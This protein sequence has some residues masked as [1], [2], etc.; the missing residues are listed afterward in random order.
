MSNNT[1]FIAPLSHV[2]PACSFFLTSQYTHGDSFFWWRRVG[3]IMSPARTK[4]TGREEHCHVSFLPFPP[5]LFA[6][7]PVMLPCSV[8]GA[9]LPLS[10]SQVHGKL[11]CGVWR[12]ACRLS[13]VA[14]R[15]SLAA[16]LSRD[17]VS[18]LVVRHAIKPA[19]RRDAAGGRVGE[20]KG[21]DSAGKTGHAHHTRTST[22]VLVLV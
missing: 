18:T 4:S 17:R 1:I 2:T 16:R 14:C 13:L 22:R 5:A 19:Q 12:V 10:L 8:C 3:V 20:N 6:P 11:A 7:R 21:L 15:L 9:S